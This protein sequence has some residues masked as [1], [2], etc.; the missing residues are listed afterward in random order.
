MR[1]AIILIVSAFISVS[2]G[3]NT[4]DGKPY[5]IEERIPW[6]TSRVVGSPDP[7]LPYRAKR[8]FSKLKFIDPLYIEVEPGTDYLLVVQQNGEILRFENDR[9]VGTTEL[10]LD[11][12]RET[13]GLTFHPDYAK[14]GYLYIVS[15][16]PEDAEFKKNRVSRFTVERKPP[17]HCDPTSEQIIIEWESNGHNGGDLAFGPDGFLYITAGDGTSSSDINLTGQDLSNLNATLMRIDVNRPDA[18]RA[19]SIPRDNP[20]LHIKDARPEIWAYGFRNPWRLTFDRQTGRLWVGNV[21]HNRWEMIHLVRRGENYGWSL[22]EG[23]H[24]FY[25]RRKPGPTPIVKPTVEHPHSEARS[26]TGGIVYYGSKF[27]ELHG[28]YIYGDYST[29]KIWGLRYGGK[30]V[31]WHKELA[32]TTIQI[33]GFGVDQNGEVLIVDYLG[34]IFQLE[35]APKDQPVS[36]FPTQLHETGL[37][38]SVK[39]HQT[40]PALIPYSVNTPLWSDGT[41]KERFIGLPGDSQIEFTTV[42]GWNFP[43]GTVLVKTFALDLETGNPASRHRI[44]TRL[45]TRQEGE[46]VGY[47]YVWN[48]KQT[49]AT[50]VH[51]TG[52]DRVFTI[53]DS[54]SP[55]GIR[56]QTWHYPSRAECMVCHTRAA[57]FVLGLTLLQMNKVHDYGHASDNQLR[58]LDG[59]DVFTQPLPVPPETYRKLVNPYNPQE[60]LGARA[61][62]YLH[63][64]CANCH[65]DGGGGNAPMVLEFTTA[66]DETNIFGAYPQH[67]T[68][69]IADAMLI[70]PGNPERSIIYHRVSRRGPGQMPPLAT[71]RVDRQAVQLLGDWITQMEPTTEEPINSSSP[72]H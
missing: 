57:N 51:R 25:L 29:G 40:V 44:E 71:S 27:P 59:I 28:T 64:N 66:Q 18:E 22:Y 11:I 36:E 33:L 48:D 10:F 24:P 42:R 23:S 65:M 70:A 34:G 13:Y 14:N 16:G 41:H 37:F 53:R 47:S 21:G 19:Y 43:D 56:E 35:R 1:P 30:V 50:L 68:F 15:N 67:D 7:P 69:G 61:R 5:G 31:T 63:A 55:G 39:G 12:G 20:F 8:T 54:R 49:N 17:Y 32:D 58:T 38:T 9:D 6:T 3:E 4:T 62:S 26:I 72:L 2:W 60:P 46:W 52:M 45:L